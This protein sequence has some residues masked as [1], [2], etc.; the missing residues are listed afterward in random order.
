MFCD[1]PTHRV[2]RMVLVASMGV[3]TALYCN[4]LIA[5]EWEFERPLYDKL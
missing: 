4:S 2:L 1:V 3:L 5:G